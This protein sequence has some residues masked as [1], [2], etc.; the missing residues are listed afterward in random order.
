MRR[1]EALWTPARQFSPLLLLFLSTVMK[2]LS[3][4]HRLISQSIN[5]H[6]STS[7][8]STSKPQSAFANNVPVGWLILN[9]A[10]GS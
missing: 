7:T 4:E 9:S 8:R 1:K 2:S 6:R 10:C 3:M 5:H